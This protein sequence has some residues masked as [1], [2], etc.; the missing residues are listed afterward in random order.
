MSTRNGRRLSVVRVLA[1]IVVVALGVTGV[2]IGLRI[3]EADANAAA[4]T[5]HFGPYVDVTATPQYAFEDATGSTQRSAILSF[6]VSSLDAPCEPSW[7]AAYP[8]A[9]AA[10]GLSLDRRVARLRQLGGELT[11]SFGGAANSELSIGCTDPT[12]LTAAY[13]S[14]VNRY[15]ATSIDLDVEG[16]IASDPAVSTR[17]GLAI[18]A[19][20]TVQAAAGTP[21][22]VWLTLPVGGSGLTAEGLGVLTATLAAKVDLAGVNG[23]TMDYGVPLPAGTSMADQGE[24]A[25]TALQQ[26]TIAA[27]AVAGITLTG[28]EGWQHVGATPMIGQNDIAGEVFGLDD[29]HQLAAFAELNQLG[30]VSMWSANRDQDCG[31]NYPNVQ[32]VSDSC[33]GVAQSPG[34]FAGI[35]GAVAGAVSPAAPVTSSAPSA[36]VAPSSAAGI[37]DDPATSPYPIWNVNQ[38]YPR[39]TQ[40]VWHRNVYQAKWYTTGDQPDIPVASADLTPWTL[41]GPVLPGETPAPTPTLPAGTYP[42]WNI[43]DVYVAGSRVLLDSVGYEAKFWNQG[44]A[45]GAPP[46]KPGETSPWEL[47]TVP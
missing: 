17:R 27:Y 10:D 6:I 34:E 40:I 47:V 16:S 37:V 43:A 35:L 44:S 2:V 18:A 38:S 29:A 1:V 23:M 36:S 15:S 33:S 7:G 20:Q 30:R 31:P 28:G 46:S 22:T 9:A 21:L 45:P 26:Q 5:S 41:I 32:V 8:L 25:L 11:V 39:G 42:E 24:A 3:K 13:Q 14:V 12:E 4:V 19:V